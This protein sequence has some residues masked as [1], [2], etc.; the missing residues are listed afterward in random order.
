MQQNLIFNKLCPNPQ[1]PVTV[2]LD[3]DR[4]E[5]RRHPTLRSLVFVL[6]WNTNL[7]FQ[8]LI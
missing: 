8:S 2:M 5:E 7:R 6:K 1:G 3:D 4:I